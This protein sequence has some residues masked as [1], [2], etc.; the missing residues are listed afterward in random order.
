MSDGRLRA[1][2]LGAAMT[3]LYALA[4]CVCFWRTLG[5]DVVFV[6]PDAPIAPMGFAEALRALFTTAP[7]LQN[8]VFLLPYPFAYEGTFWGDGYVMCLAGVFLLRGRGS[9]WGAAWVGG[10]CVA[11]AGYFATLFCAG[12]R[13][14]VDALA[15]TC[16]VFG[17]VLRGVRTGRARWWALAGG[18]A[19]LGLAAQADI[20]LIVLCGVAA[21]GLWLV[22]VERPAWR[23]LALGLVVAA[24]VFLVVGW[25]ALRHTFRDAQTTRAAQLTQAT[26][27]ART[28]A[29]EAEARWRF[30]T[31]WSLPPEDLAEL[32][33]PGIHGHTSYP[34]DPEPY[35]GRMGSAVQTLRQHT[36]HIGW[37][38]MLLALLALSRRREAD[39]R[40][41]PFWLGL[42]AVTLVLALG[43]H[44][45]VYRL[46]AGLPFIDQIRA[47]VKWWHLTG[48]AVGIAA[49]LGAPVVLGRLRVPAVALCAA[50]AACGVLVVRP[51]VFPRDLSHNALTAALPPGATV[52]NPLRWSELDAICAWQGIPVEGDLAK[53]DYVVAPAPQPRLPA[54]RATLTVQGV[55]LGL[56]RLR[57]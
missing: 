26:A 1:W 48:F 11:F 14:V 41:L 25:P 54:P 31:D 12:H 27:L 24:G 9:S 57:P 36:V 39:A 21:Y 47:P 3:A 10:F 22:C 6:A 32:A 51:Y 34:F 13:G 37:P 33:V 29:E 49:G 42:A 53:A 38:A 23:R 40:D 45:P 50:V 20:W 30:V 19:A 17:A 43:R 7:T 4:V 16:L 15:V 56:Y 5:A 52:A 44:T 28:P 8:L 55:T 18:F 46:V 35:T 2:A